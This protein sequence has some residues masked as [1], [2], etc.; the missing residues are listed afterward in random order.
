MSRFHYIGSP[1]EP[2]L[3]V[4]GSI[5]SPEDVSG[6][7]PVQAV[8]FKSR[9]L[10]E[11]SVPLEQI[12]D[13]SHIT[14]EETEV[15]DS[16]EHAAGI[17]IQH[18]SPWNEA[19]RKHFTNAYVYEIAPVWGKFVLH[20]DMQRMFPD[21]YLAHLKS[22]RELFRLT[23]EFGENEEMFELYSCWIGEESEEKEQCLEWSLE[24][25]SA[26]IEDGFELME[27]QY[28]RIRIN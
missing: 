3:G 27:K 1:R 7:K 5:K 28:I 16:M 22:I 25:V 11:G 19:I 26:R 4:R 9:K 6:N 17:L 8:R 23:R 13:L 12:I 15:Y 2:P 20:P 24:D 21:E 14:P 10:P 18:L